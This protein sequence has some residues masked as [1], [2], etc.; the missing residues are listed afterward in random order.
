[1]C[2]GGPDGYRDLSVAGAADPLGACAAACCAW[3]ACAAWIVR[4]LAGTDGNCTNERC[5]WL[6]PDCTPGET[7]HVPGATAQFRAAAPGPPLPRGVGGY[8]V[9]LDARTN[10]LTVARCAS[11]GVCTTMGVFDT[12]TL[13]NGIVLGAWNMLRVLLETDGASGALSLRVF[14]NP[15]VP[16]TGFTGVP[17]DDAARVP[18]SLPP[19]LALIDA[20]PLPSG[21]LLVAAGGADARIDYV[22]ALPTRVL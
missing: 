9:T 15:T 11:G 3:D 12:T 20:A 1:V 13:E 19:R 8:N 17:A 14:F 2:P 10:T 16:E 4:D 22:S 5:C 21:G 18:R 6:K 7:A